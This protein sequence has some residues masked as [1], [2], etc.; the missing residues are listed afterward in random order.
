M[1]ESFGFLFTIIFAASA[2]LL[3][4]VILLQPGKSGGGAL[5]F[6]G[7]TSQTIFGA[8]GGV[9]FLAKVTVWAAVFFMV[10]SMVLA[11]MSH[12]RSAIADKIKAEQTQTQ[13]ADVPAPAGDALPSSDAKQDQQPINV[14]LDGGQPIKLNLGGKQVDAIPMNP[15]DGGAPTPPPPPADKK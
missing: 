1:A 2:V 12:S 13:K 6:G 14:P 10:S 4:I 7:P 11:Y 8:S 5:G 9:T 15:S 3:V